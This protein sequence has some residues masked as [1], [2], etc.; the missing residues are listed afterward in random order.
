[1]YLRLLG[2]KPD[3][4]VTL[5]PMLQRRPTR[6]FNLRTSYFT[7]AV[8]C[9]GAGN[10]GPSRGIQYLK[11]RRAYQRPLRFFAA[12]RSAACGRYLQLTL[13]GKPCK[14]VVTLRGAC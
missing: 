9:D 11:P 5:D 14:A 13:S 6:A 3:M 7:G 12:S 1:M 2:G 8:P 4:G 10:H